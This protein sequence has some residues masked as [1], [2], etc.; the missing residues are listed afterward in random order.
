MQKKR[1]LVV[2]DERHM[3]RLL[4]FTLEKTGAVVQTAGSGQEA[5]ECLRTEPADLVC[6]DLVMPGMDG[7]DTVR[8][9]RN[10]PALKDIPVIMLTSRGWDETREKASGLRIVAYFTKPFSPT[11]LIAQAKKILGL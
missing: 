9:I 4:Q 10:E 3:Q 2:D 1:I 7:F 5:I 6:L 11:E 8:E